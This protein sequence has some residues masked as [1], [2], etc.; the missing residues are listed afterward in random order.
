MG[1]HDS[2]L[3]SA[4]NTTLTQH[5]PLRRH[6]PH[7]ALGASPTFPQACP[8]LLR[9]S[10]PPE[11]GQA[12]AQ[13]LQP[14]REKPEGGATRRAREELCSSPGRRHLAWHRRPG[15]A[16]RGVLALDGEALCLVI[17]K[18]PTRWLPRTP[19]ACHGVTIHRLRSSA[20]AD[21]NFP[22]EIES[23]LR[24]EANVVRINV[25]NFCGAALACTDGSC[26]AKAWA[27]M[28]E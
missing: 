17:G 14:P 16:L 5:P 4:S 26:A 24:P 18:I 8:T 7:V 22:R 3:T 27:G 1:L 25:G 19:M 23:V 12:A 10:T 2:T 13:P 11:R 9:G 20:R 21:A 28:S 6:R 15:S